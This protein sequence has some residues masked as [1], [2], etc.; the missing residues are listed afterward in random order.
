M[1]DLARQ[2]ITDM[3]PDGS[4]RN[5]GRAGGSP[6]RGSPC[7]GCGSLYDAQARVLRVPART[8]FAAPPGG[9]IGRT[10]IRIG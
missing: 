2:H 5:L 3:R 4:R 9:L 6:G 7:C 8:K 10:A 1:A